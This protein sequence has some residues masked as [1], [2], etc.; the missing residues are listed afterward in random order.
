MTYLNPKFFQQSNDHDSE[1]PGEEWISPK[2]NRR[3]Y[4]YSPFDS[5]LQVSSRNSPIHFSRSPTPSFAPKSKS[6]NFDF[7][8]LLPTILLGILL[9][10]TAALIIKNSLSSKGG[11]PISK[12]NLYPRQ[13]KRLTKI[14]NYIYNHPDETENCNKS[15]CIPDSELSSEVFSQ[16]HDTDGNIDELKGLFQKVGIYHQYHDDTKHCYFIYD[17]RQ[18]LKCDAVNYIHQNPFTSM[19]II[20]TTFLT[21]YCFIHVKLNQR[22]KRI[23][24]SKTNHIIDEM[25]NQ[26]KDSYIAADFEPSKD[27]SDYKYWPSVMIEIEKNRNIYTYNSNRGKV[28]KPQSNNSFR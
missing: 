5:P 27:S 15:L 25:I 4:Q 16:F 26:G 20:I 7:W 1:P 14:K 6:R 10:S 18:T 21:V 2:M 12:G 28:W 13:I 19:L 11:K 9:L 24:A 22:K 8:T 17:P 23:I 3:V